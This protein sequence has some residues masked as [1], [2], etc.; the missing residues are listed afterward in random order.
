MNVDLLNSIVEETIAQ[1]KE[2]EQQVKMAETGLREMVSGAEQVRQ[3]YAQLMNWA[4]LF[5]KCSF[6]SKK[7]IAAQF[8][9]AVHVKRDYEI[10][11]EFNVAFDEFQQIYLE[12]EEG[13]RTRGATTIPALAEK[14]GQAVQ[15]LAPV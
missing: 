4:E 15:P 9:K 14:S 5:D 11:V 1:I 8:I 13:E 2:L 12:S 7:M 3:D 10:D 6:E